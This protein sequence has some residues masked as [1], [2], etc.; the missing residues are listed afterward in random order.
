MFGQRGGRATAK[1]FAEEGAAVVAADIDSE[2]V[3]ETADRIDAPATRPQDV[4]AALLRR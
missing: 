4:R 2:S 3:A 1:R